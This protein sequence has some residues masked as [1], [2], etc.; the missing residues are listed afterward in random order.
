MEN[1]PP[2]DTHLLPGGCGCP[3]PTGDQAP[4]LSGHDVH[5]HLKTPPKIQKQ[6]QQAATKVAQTIARLP[7]YVSVYTKAQLLHAY[8]LAMTIPKPSSFA[9]L[10]VV[11]R[12]ALWTPEKKMHS[13]PAAVALACAPE[14]HSAFGRL[15]L[16]ISVP[17]C[18]RFGRAFLRGF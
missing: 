9:T 6:R 2:E 14:K 7:K 16:T 3:R 10:E 12:R 17:F 8:G 15:S 5:I 11:F 1:Q 13:W 4:D 18:F